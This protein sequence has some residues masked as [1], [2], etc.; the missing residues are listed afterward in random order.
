MLH[1][2]PR[3]A[4]RLGA[5]PLPSWGRAAAQGARQPRDHAIAWGRRE[6]GGRELQLVCIDTGGVRRRTTPRK[7]KGRAAAAEMRGREGVTRRWVG[8][9][10][11]MDA[12]GGRRADGEA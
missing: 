5:R 2:R 1:D 6:G 8:A 4:P 10:A 7:P 9:P 3:C 12:R 11:T